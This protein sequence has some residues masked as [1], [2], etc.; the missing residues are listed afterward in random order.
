[1]PSNGIQQEAGKGRGPR[2]RAG[3]WWAEGAPA[4]LPGPG[5]DLWSGRGPDLS[6]RPV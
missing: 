1:M 4:R 3:A 6:D 2:W 5:V